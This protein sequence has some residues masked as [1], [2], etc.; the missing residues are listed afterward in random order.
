MLLCRRILFQLEFRPFRGRVS[1]RRTISFTPALHQDVASRQIKAPWTASGLFDMLSALSENAKTTDQVKDKITVLQAYKHLRLLDRQSLAALPLASYFRLL[2][3]ATKQ[4][5]GELCSQLVEDMLDC[6]PKDDLCPAALKIMSSHTL[7]LLPPRT[8][9]LLVQCLESFPGGLNQLSV[10][11]AA[12]LVHTFAESPCDKTDTT[13]LESIY[14]L[15]LSHLKNIRPPEDDA[16]LTYKPPDIIHASFA[17]IHKLL[18]LSEQ[19]RA[20]EIFQFLVNSG[21]IPSEAVQTLPGLDGFDGIVRSSLVRACMNWHWRPL[22][23]RF[24]SPL[25]KPDTGPHAIT[26]AKDTL[27]ACLNQPSVED[28]AACRS[29]ICRIHPFSPVPNGVIREYYDTAHLVGAAQ[30]ARALYAFTRLDEVFEKHR[31]PC[32]R[33]DALAWLL[34]YLLEINSHLAQELARE[35]LER[36][37]PVPAEFRA[38]IVKQLAQRGHAGVARSLWSKYAV[39]KERQAFLADPSMFVRM[40]SL[41]HHLVRRDDQTLE[42]RE[43]RGEDEGE[44]GYGEDETVENDDSGVEAIRQRRDDCKEF[45]DFVMSEF[46]LA[47]PPMAQCNHQVITSQARAFFIV[48][49]FVRGFET[50]K[51]LL[52]RKEMPDI[53][54]VNVTLTIMAEHDPR[55]AA[56]IVRRMEEKGLQPD[57]VTF[58]TIMHHALAHNDM[59]LVDEMVQRVAGLREQLSY[60]SIASLIRGSIAFDAGS[61]PGHSAQTKLRNAFEI[62]KSIRRSPVMHTASLGKFLVYA[63]LQASDPTM[64]FKFWELLIKDKAR[65]EDGEHTALRRVI[66]RDLAAHTRKKWIKEMHARAMISQLRMGDAFSKYKDIRY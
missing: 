12:V 34:R 41:F 2:A 37:I 7:P 61:I 35:I 23:E 15:L 27:Y 48:G 60:K 28:L 66:V 8:I 54:D 58:G 64:A 18:Q 53:Y 11:T 44:D 1:S 65:K 33:A 6:V 46:A 49:D 22:A 19:Q 50:I 56:Q 3:K 20:L 38:S 62:L 63:C 57:Q 36:N 10:Q 25:L 14:P 13:L 47:H 30:E 29:L 24:L 5:H 42:A 4:R 55:A 43:Q 31:Y 32:P 51:V 21:N 26:L 59:E 16:I 17:F 39:G 52:E 9:L 40:V 45:L